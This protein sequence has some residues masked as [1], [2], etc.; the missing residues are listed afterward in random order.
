MLQ[1]HDGFRQSPETR[2]LISGSEV[3]GWLVF[4]HQGQ[5]T[6]QDVTFAVKTA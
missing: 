1:S 3:C 2:V 4:S 6:E 5:V